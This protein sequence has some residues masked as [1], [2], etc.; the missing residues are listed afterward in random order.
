V[1]DTTL[2]W[3]ILRW[4]A[5][6][7]ITLP[8]Q[9]VADERRLMARVV[10][11]RLGLRLLHQLK[12][13]HHQPRWLSEWGL[14]HLRGQNAKTIAQI[15]MRFRALREIDAALPH[16]PPLLLKGFA[17]YAATGDSRFLRPSGDLDLL[18][19]DAA[20]FC[21]ALQSLGYGTVAAPATA[22]EFA[23]AGRGSVGIEIHRFFPA[24]SFPRGMENDKLNGNVHYQTFTPPPR[25]E[26]QYDD[27]WPHAVRAKAPELAGLCVPD[28]TTTAFLLCAH[29]FRELIQS[30]FE[31]PVPVRMA[32]L[33]DI[34]DLAVHPDFD[35]ARFSELAR[36]WGD[37]CVRVMG[38]FFE[39][40]FGS[41]P[42]PCGALPLTPGHLPRQIGVRGVWASLGTAREWLMGVEHR[43]ILQRL[44][45]SIASQGA[46]QSFI[47]LL[48]GEPFTLQL[49]Q[50]GTVDGFYLHLHL[51]PLAQSHLEYKV[52]LENEC[53]LL[54]AATLFACGQW[55]Q[56]G[57]AHSTCQA[58]FGE[59]GVRWFIPASSAPLLLNVTR[60]DAS[61]HDF[62]NAQ[63]VA[64][65]LISPHTIFPTYTN[66]ANNLPGQRS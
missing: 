26:I 6:A 60:R 45:N 14:A 43:E 27:I 63:C 29:E 23:T 40:V 37:S 1:Q 21:E 10:T 47:H 46:T 56:N 59:A 4:A 49:Q 25:R 9:P 24:Y 8:C 44:Q 36:Q 51:P 3:D 58:E 31:L 39:T 11:H 2:E 13:H 30:P 34:Y 7:N 22:H 54:N 12:T 28:V 19:P 15:E 41:N 5:G 66:P 48:S 35:A 52:R 33:A 61:I 65:A 16:A 62:Y 18:A 42:L 64:L 57:D 55:K 32:L 53:G 38:H 50:E 17:P 20:A